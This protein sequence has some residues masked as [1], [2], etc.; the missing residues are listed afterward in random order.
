MTKIRITIPA[1][2]LP[3]F[4]HLARKHL[5]NPAT[6]IRYPSVAE[7]VLLEWVLSSIQKLH[8]ITPQASAKFSVKHSQALALFETLSSLEIYNELAQID[9]N[10][11]INSIA[12]QLPRYLLNTSP[13]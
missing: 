11:L 12:K 1:S 9:R 10:E 4:K 5:V 7:L 13:V 6:S 3:Y 2:L 8:A